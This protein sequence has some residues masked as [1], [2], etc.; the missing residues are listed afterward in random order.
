MSGTLEWRPVK[1][2]WNYGAKGKLR[3]VMYDKGLSVLDRSHLQWLRGFLDAGFDE[4]E[5]LIDAINSHNEIEI[6]ISY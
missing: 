5:D 2:D 3:D 1:N 4:A 6:K